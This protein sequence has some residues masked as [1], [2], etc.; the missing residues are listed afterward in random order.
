MD[1]DIREETAAD[2]PAVRQLAAEAFAAA[3]HSAPPVGADGVPGEATLVGWLRDTDA[4]E[5]E[6]ALVAS[7]E[8]A[9]VG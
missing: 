1:I 5:S 6:F 2:A 3:E 8:G 4:Y 7:D 9:T